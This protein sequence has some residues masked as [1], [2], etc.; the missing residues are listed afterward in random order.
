MRRFKDHQHHLNTLIMLH[1]GEPTK[2][3]AD[4]GYIG[5]ADEPAIILVTPERSLVGSLSIGCR[6]GIIEICH[7]LG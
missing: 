7:Q 4:K 3:L 5:E 2:I 1:K 6:R